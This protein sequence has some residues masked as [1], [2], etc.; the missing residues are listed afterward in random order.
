MKNYILIIMLLSILGTF[1]VNA[2][3]D[4]GDFDQY[5]EYELDY[6]SDGKLPN[7]RTRHK[8]DRAVGF[9]YYIPFDWSEVNSNII[10][11]STTIVDNK[12]R[13]TEKLIPNFKYYLSDKTNLV[14][15]LYMKRTSIKYEGDIDTLITPSGLLSHKEH[16]VQNGFYG[17][18][19]YDRHLA[20]PSF[21]RFDLDFYA[22]AALSFGFA[23]ANNKTYDEFSNGD[24]AETITSSNRIGFGLDL[25]TGV[26]FQFNNFSVGLEMIALGFDSN[27]GV[28]KSKVKRSTTIGGD[29]TVE[30]YFTYDDNP[31]VAYSKLKLSRNL[32]SMYRGVRISASYYFGKVDKK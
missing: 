16:F 24:D 29:V 20:Q 32:T 26:N 25:Y 5:T 4:Y 11:D 6:I 22:G 9:Y 17:R 21:R 19:G 23:P 12:H 2:Q 31:G 7:Y 10:G 13:V 28:G 15:G 27:I 14:F 8:G 1:E 30:E 18:I 3:I